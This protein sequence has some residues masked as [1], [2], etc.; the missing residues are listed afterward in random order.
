MKMSATIH[1]LPLYPRGKSPWYLLDRIYGP[2]SRYDAVEK[3]KFLHCRESNLDRPAHSP[4]LYRLSYPDSCMCGKV[5]YFCGELFHVQRDSDA[6]RKLCVSGSE[7]E[8]ILNSVV[9]WEKT[10][11]TQLLKYSL[12]S[13][14]P[15]VHLH[16]PSRLNPIHRLFISRSNLKLFTHLYL[17]L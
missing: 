17:G 12:P 1:S 16:I 14:N 15:Y 10:I 5:S 7:G 13:C 6:L 9:F 11:A 8:A 3:R 4:S 2:Q